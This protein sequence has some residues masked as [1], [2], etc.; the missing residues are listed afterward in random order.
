M[1]SKIHEY[2]KNQFYLM[3]KN[4]KLM[5]LSACIMLT[6]CSQKEL[7]SGITKKKHGHAGKTRR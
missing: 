2:K 4:I 3:S 6:A 7:T 1:K 5:A